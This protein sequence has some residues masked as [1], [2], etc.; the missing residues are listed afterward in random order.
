MWFV[1]CALCRVCVSHWLAQRLHICSNCSTSTQQPCR[2]RSLC[3]V[4]ATFLGAVACG[5]VFDR[6]N[7]ELQLIIVNCVQAVSTI[8]APFFTTLPLFIAMMFIQSISQGF[9]DASK[10][11]LL[12]SFRYWRLFLLKGKPPN[13][14]SWLLVN[15]WVNPNSPP[16]GIG[17]PWPKFWQHSSTMLRL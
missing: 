10:L 14:A 1:H 5:F 4:S 3:P 16:K 2:G 15:I 13:L 6:F 12:L 11:Q 8:I 7:H 17:Y 9:I